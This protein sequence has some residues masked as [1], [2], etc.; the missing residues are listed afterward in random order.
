MSNQFTLADFDSKEVMERPDFVL[1]RHGIWPK[2][3][4]LTVPN[5]FSNEIIELAHFLRLK[6]KIYCD[7]LAAP[8]VERVYLNMEV[9]S[10]FVARLD[11]MKKASRLASQSRLPSFWNVAC[12]SLISFRL[13]V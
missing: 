2:H 4:N 3:M 7:P 8:P 5:S 10:D 6:C 9:D 13:S 11:L 1:P 12:K